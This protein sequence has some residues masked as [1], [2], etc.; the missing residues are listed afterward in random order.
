MISSREPAGV[1]WKPVCAVPALTAASVRPTCACRPIPRPPELA[2]DFRSHE[3]V[4]SAVFSVASRGE[5]IAASDNQLCRVTGSR[6]CSMIAGTAPI[7]ARL[8][9][10]SRST[11]VWFSS[12]PAQSSGMDLRTDRITCGSCSNESIRPTNRPRPELSNSFR[13]ASS[14]K[15]THRGSQTGGNRRFGKAADTG[16]A[17]KDRSS[18]F[19]VGDWFKFLRSWRHLRPVS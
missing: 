8:R 18:R 17:Q 13:S 14:K 15:S 7:T 5:S 4:A 10:T 6:S 1:M 12:P 11:S 19:S 3:Q 9:E 16:T 2:I